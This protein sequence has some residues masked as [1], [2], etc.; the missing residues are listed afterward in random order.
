VCLGGQTL[1]L[2]AIERLDRLGVAPII[3]VLPPEPDPIALPPGL[4]V[5]RNHDV[6]T[7]QLGSTCLGLQACPDDLDAVVVYPVDHHAVTDADLAVLLEGLDH[8][9][10]SVARIVP[11]WGGRGG[12]PI[13]LLSPALRELRQVSDSEATTLREVL[14]RAGAVH[15]VQATSSGVRR[16]LNT[17]EDLPAD[18]GSL[19]SEAQ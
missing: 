5:V 17:P 15:P 10:P 6:D 1:L 7:G 4:I 12:H 3:A 2:R 9:S 13:L 8:A 18:A 11:R 14:D 16:N 19:A